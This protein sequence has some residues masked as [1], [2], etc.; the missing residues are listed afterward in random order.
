M[1]GHNSFQT[2][3]Y[4]EFFEC[5]DSSLLLGTYIMVAKG[6]N[7]I[8]KPVYVEVF[9]Y[10][11]G[12]PGKMLSRELLRPTTAVYNDGAVESKTKT[13]FTNR[14]NYHRFATP[15]TVGKRFFVGYEISYPLRAVSDSFQVYG[16]LRNTSI[17][18]AYFQKERA[19]YPFNMHAFYPLNTSIWIDPVI[20]R[21]TSSSVRIAR[22]TVLSRITQPSIFWSRIYSTLEISFPRI[23][24]GNTQLELLDMT[25][26][27]VYSTNVYPPR[28]SLVLKDLTP[29]VYVIRLRNRNNRT[30]QKIAVGYN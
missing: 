4:A 1:F 24:V 7:T 15:V 14:E 28:A 2:K 27:I 6:K 23:W 8:D 29:R 18:T 19:W 26:K 22:D 21:D 9:E 20:M 25:G 17:N 12:I 5:S 16:A 11:R 30:I 13:Y 10:D 3:R